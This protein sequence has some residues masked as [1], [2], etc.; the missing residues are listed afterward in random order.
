MLAKTEDGRELIKRSRRRGRREGIDKVESGDD[1]DSA[2]LR[3]F[4]EAVA[5]EI[6]DG[7]GGWA[8]THSRSRGGVVRDDSTFLN[9]SYPPPAYVHEDGGRYSWGSGGYDG[10]VGDSRGWSSGGDSGYGNSGDNGGI[11]G[12][13]DSGGSSSGGDSGGA[14]SS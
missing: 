7:S 3:R 1:S 9:P 2:L 13:G 10:G 8:W 5:N 12:G 11:S 14:S 6:M 4:A